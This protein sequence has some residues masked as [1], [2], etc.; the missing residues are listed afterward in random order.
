MSEV[1]GVRFKRAGRV[2]YF[3]PA[4]IELEPNDYVIVETA[5][6]Q[7]VGRVAIAPGQVLV[8]EIT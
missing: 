4:G 3:D 2:Y 7:D 1:V 5:H 6:G 8:S